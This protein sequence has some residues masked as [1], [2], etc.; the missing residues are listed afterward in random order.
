MESFEKR[1]ERGISNMG[2][3]LLKGYV[4]YIFNII[5]YYKNNKM[6]IIYYNK[7]IININK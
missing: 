4:R 5:K 6:F 2:E 1:N 3:L 7:I